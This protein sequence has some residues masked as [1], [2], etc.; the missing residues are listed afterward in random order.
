[1]HIEL[2][3]LDCFRSMQASLRSLDLSYNELDEVPFEAL[4]SIKELDWL[5]LHR[6]VCLYV[7]H[8]Y[9]YY[10]FSFNQ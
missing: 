9:I 1:M 8:F 7:I 6:W 2:S 5:N 10:V 4:H 3:I